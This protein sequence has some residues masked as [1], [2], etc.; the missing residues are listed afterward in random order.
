MKKLIALLLAIALLASLTACKSKQPEEEASSLTDLAEAAE[1]EAQAG[2]PEPEPD[3]E[4][5]REPEPADQAV[6][7]PEGLVGT[8]RLSGDNDMEALEAVFPEA[9]EIGGVMEI[10]MDGLMF[11]YIGTFG[12]AGTFTVDGE[13]LNAEIYPD[14]SGTPEPAVCTADEAAGTLTMD[15]KGVSIVWV[16]D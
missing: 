11:W 2:T 14:A 7:T 3:P 6:V 15:Y 8:W 1:A 9:G 16:Q 13:T 10:G 5:V 4:P 12:G